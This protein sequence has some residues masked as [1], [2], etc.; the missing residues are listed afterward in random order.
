[1]K[2]QQFMHFDGVQRRVREA[3]RLL[4]LVV[5]TY[6]LAN[7]LMVVECTW[8]YADRSSLEAM[9]LLHEYT[10]DVVSLLTVVAGA[11]RLPIYWATS[12]EVMLV[13]V[14]FVSSL[15]S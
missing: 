11:V 13:T 15:R 4:V 8:E 14:V 5:C 12:K 3:T 6:L 10:S 9:P 2:V 7:V 1:M